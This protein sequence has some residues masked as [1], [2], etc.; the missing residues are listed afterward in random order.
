MMKRAKKK[1]AK[2]PAGKKKALK[3]KTAKRT[4]KKSSVKKPSVS[5][6]ARKPGEAGRGL[7]DTHFHSV[8]S[9]A[10]GRAHDLEMNL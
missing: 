2:K 9:V 5:R 6:N 10:I 3:A 1:I 4:A 7:C 8:G